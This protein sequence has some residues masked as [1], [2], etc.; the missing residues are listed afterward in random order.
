M[1]V[2]E[3]VKASIGQ[4]II[5][6]ENVIEQVLIAILAGGHALLE[7][8]PG[9]GK[10]LLVRTI[11]QSLDLSFSRIQ[12]TPDLMPADIVGTQIITTDESGKTTFR[13]Q[14][15]PVFGHLVL[16]DE[17]NRA[18]PK[19]QS[20][21]LEAMQ[22][23]T[24]T[25]AGESRRLPE[26]F[27]VLA[28]QNPLEMEG[29][30]VLPEAQLDRFLL[31][32]V[33]DFPTEA[34]L[35]QIVIQTSSNRKVEIG[36]VADGATLQEMQATVRDLLVPD[37]VVEAGVHLLMMTHPSHAGAPPSIRQYVRAGAGPRGVQALVQAAKARAFLHRRFNASREDL[38]AVAPAVFRHRILRNFEAEAVG[39]TTDQLVSDLLTEMKKGSSL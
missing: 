18:T 19:T 13:F 35:K 27:F 9:L 6:Q 12:F 21:L 24:V 2:I 8:V 37:E 11:S 33:V 23:H 16:A 36:K 31:K 34:E 39:I 3:Q 1:D 14:P 26:P 15:G 28:T 30:Y 32:I 22:E 38:E 29:T 4:V 25:V 20:A 7:G 5:G 10:T 17:I